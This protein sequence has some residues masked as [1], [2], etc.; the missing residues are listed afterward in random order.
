MYLHDH[1]LVFPEDS[2]H[3]QCNGKTTAQEKIPVKAK[4][5]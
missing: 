2:Y 1:V 4:I 3:S 5:A